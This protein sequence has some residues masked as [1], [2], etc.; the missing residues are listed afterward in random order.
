MIKKLLSLLLVFCMVSLPVFAAEE[1]PTHGNMLVN[2]DLEACKG[3]TLSGWRVASGT[4]KVETEQVH[5]GKNAVYMTHTE[6]MYMSQTIKPI[7]GETY[8]VSF[9]A[10]LAADNTNEK[11]QAAIKLEGFDTAQTNNI[12]ITKAF[13]LSTRWQEFSFEAAM[14]EDLGHI[15]V[16]VRLF[17]GGAIILD[18]ISFEGKLPEDFSDST[19][20]YTVKKD[21]KKVPADGIRESIDGKEYFQNPSF[22]DGDA[23]PADWGAVGG[24]WED[25]QWVTYE[26][27]TS[28]DGERSVKIT[29]DGT[30]YPWVNQLVPDLTPGA[31]YQLTGWYNSNVPTAGVLWK[32][33]FY[34]ENEIK[35]E[36]TVSSST[37]LRYSGTGGAWEQII[38][39]FTMPDG[40]KAVAIYPRLMAASGTVF[41]DDM[42]LTLIENPSEGVLETDEVIYYADA[43]EG[44]ARVWLRSDAHSGGSVTFTV[45]DSAGNTFAKAENV[46]FAHGENAVWKF[47][48]QNMTLTEEYTLTA[49][50][51]AADGTKA[52]THSSFVYRYERP[53]VIDENGIYRNDDGTPFY[54]TIAYHAGRA[55]EELSKIGVNVVQGSNYGVEGYLKILDEADKYGMKILITLYP[56]M[57]PAGAPENVENTTAIVNAV[58]DH[59]ATFAYAVQDEPF[60]HNPNCD[61]DLRKSYRLIRSLDPKHPVYICE[62]FEE[63]YARAGKYVDVLCI[64]PYPSNASHVGTR[65]A[66]QTELALEAVKYNKPVYV[67]ESVFTFSSFRP[68][69][70]EIRTQNYQTLL[71]GG[72]AWGFY[73]YNPDNAQLDKK[74]PESIFWEHMVSFYEEED[75]LLREY[76]YEEKYPRFNKGEGEGY[77][78]ESFAADGAVYV[79]TYNTVRDKKTAE[80]PLVSDNKRITLSGAS[81]ELVAGADS[82]NAKVE[83][84]K[85]V[86]D[87]T[88]TQALLYKITPAEAIDTA[89]LSETRFTDTA[90]YS[91]ASE[92][93]KTLEDRGTA[94]GDTEFAPGEAITRGDFAL[95]LV[96]TLDLFF[97]TNS[98]FDDVDENAEYAEALKKGRVYG[99]LNGIGDNKFS[100]EATIT[101][102]DLMTIISRG[103]G[104]AG[105]ADL[106]AFS[107]AGQIADYALPHVSAMVEAGLVAGNA[108]GTLNPLG[109]ATRAEAA[110]IMQ[111]ILNR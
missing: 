48:V 26:K 43:E 28:L 52:E 22:E 24:K 94:N 29:S 63:C 65:V 100:P 7:P 73:P 35:G 14:P 97:T 3:E 33:E 71:A 88:E 50:L 56:G 84:D 92:A 10:R 46:P 1:A 74:L 66:E 5:G 69:G 53:S 18:D 38:S 12:N 77:K 60:A 76:F 101:R 72:T 96:E 54:P 21:A 108:D 15:N 102:Q 82:L 59:P 90:S 87:M 25:N 6:N 106:S 79:A 17:N 98:Q 13:N 85:L 2:G 111:R 70:Y 83:G 109:N 62:C 55:F 93:I 20:G 81:V 103:L 37:T 61:D 47:P 9:W 34:S 32:F 31:T 42:S 91:W 30:N 45:T 75:T 58:K 16:L 40:A 27:E 41:F 8:T 64:D 89:L 67:L 104:L 11:V 99:I 23:S 86:V 80:I 105:E 51:Y 68:E 36:Y 107:D 44:T 49:D 78:W 57:L 19:L 39:N 110:V 4:A 95:F